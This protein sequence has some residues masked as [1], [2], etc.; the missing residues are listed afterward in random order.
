MVF[1]TNQCLEFEVPRVPKVN[2]NRMNQ[3][4]LLAAMTLKTSTTF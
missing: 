4:L 1:V 3:F 2:N